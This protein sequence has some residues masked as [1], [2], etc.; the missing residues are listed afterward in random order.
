MACDGSGTTAEVAEAA[1]KAVV[2]SRASRRVDD[3]S[4]E[5]AEPDEGADA[6]TAT[7]LEALGLVALE[8]IVALETGDF[9]ET[10]MLATGWYPGDR[11][12]MFK[13]RRSL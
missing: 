10:S 2:A 7:R 4:A 5:R 12:Y 8:E 6:R 3:T 11:E 9:A 1:R 13:C